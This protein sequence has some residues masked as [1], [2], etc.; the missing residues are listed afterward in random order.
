MAE[1]VL[2]TEIVDYTSKYGRQLRYPHSPICV[3]C[4]GGETGRQGIDGYWGLLLLRRG[5]LCN[6]RRRM[7][8]CESA[9]LQ[10]YLVPLSCEKQSVCNWG[11]RD[12]SL[13]EG[14]AK[15]E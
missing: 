6:L 8:G 5:M 7:G 2:D 13:I 9:Q 14:L 10:G 4:E 15:L 12:S 3:T 1:I 11:I